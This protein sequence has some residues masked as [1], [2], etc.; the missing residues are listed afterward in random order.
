MGFVQKI[1]IK[2]EEQ[3]RLPMFCNQTKWVTACHKNKRS[4]LSSITTNEEIDEV[5]L[6]AEMDK[7]LRFKMKDLRLSRKLD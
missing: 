2:Y 5:K 6:P 7:V 4:L 3:A 1:S